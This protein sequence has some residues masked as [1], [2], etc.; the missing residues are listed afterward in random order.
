MRK[1]LFLLKILWIT[2]VIV[3]LFSLGV[4]AEELNG[5]T[6]LNPD[7]FP[8]TSLQKKISLLEEETE[9]PLNARIVSLLSLS[10]GSPQKALKLLPKIEAI[11]AHFNAAEKYLMLVIKAN[12]ASAPG[13]EHKVINWLN[14]ALTLEKQID[15]EQL[16][17]P[18][19]NQSYLTLS[20]NYAINGQF[21][22]A[23]DKKREYMKRFYQYRMALEDSRIKQLNKKYDTDLKLKENELLQSQHEFETIQLQKTEQRN[24]TQQRNIFILLSIS[25]I[26]LIL[27]F[28]QI[29]IRSMLRTLAKTDSLTGLNNRKTIF[30]EG[31]KLVLLAAEKQQFLSIILFD[32]DDFK[33]INDTYGHQAGDEVIKTIASLGN[34]IM[35]SRDALSR[36]GG[37]EFAAIL[38]GTNLEQAKAFAERLREKVESLQLQHKGADYNVTISAGVANLQQVEQEFEHLLKAADHAMSLAKNAGRNCVCCF[39]SQDKRLN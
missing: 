33:S 7:N 23:F 1:G 18:I 37:E 28:R 25:L 27:L 39:K 5:D 26:I 13:Q 10:E 11:S 8:R 12:I 35:R 16:Q 38:P 2:A 32:I 36:L 20:I 17:L 21:Q 9:L 29:R 31:K 4:V 30:E 3:N 34:E 19:F 22:E 14:Q 6:T 15:M 24:I